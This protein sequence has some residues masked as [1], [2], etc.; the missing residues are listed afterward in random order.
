MPIHFAL[1]RSVLL[2]LGLWASGGF[3]SLNIFGLLWERH[4]ERHGHRHLPHVAEVFAPVA[5][6]QRVSYH[7]SPLS[8]P[9]TPLGA[10]TAA[11][12]GSAGI[13]HSRLRSAA[14]IRMDLAAE[15]GLVSVVIPTH[16]RAHILGRA[17]ES[18]LAQTYRNLQV[19]IADDGSSDDTRS[20][21]ESYGPRITYVR[22]GNA[23]VSAARNFGMRHSRG[24]FIAFLDSDDR[25]QPWKIEAQVNAL[26]RNPD[27]GLVWTDMAAVD[28]AGRLVSD[29]YLRVMY[30][31][32]ERVNFDKSLPQV[33][34]LGDLIEAFG[35][36]PPRGEVRKGDLYSDIL[37]G[38]LIHTSTVLFRRAWCER[39]GGFDE[40]YARAGEDYEFYIRLCSCGP[41]VFINAPST[42]YR[43]GAG[44]Q[45]TAPSMLLEIA[46]NNLRAIQTWYPRSEL[47]IRLSRRVIR[48]RFA[49]S[50]AWLGEAELDAGHRWNAAR[51]L[52]KSVAVMPAL[53]KRVLLV[54]SCVFP[55]GIRNRLLA[56]SR[57]VRATGAKIDG[58]LV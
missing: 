1:S 16:N 11:G 3:F 26:G 23:G 12:V 18:V 44:D 47:Q 46:R 53:D 55:A 37:L 56:A 7:A 15:P 41:V 4:K 45:L 54:A 42:F 58:R 52:S 27:A 36:S 51:Q 49:E 48:R 31:A 50:Y 57:A 17:I 28:E 5:A 8:T 32:Y 13:S 14:P 30:S 33:A 34:N 10:R 43:V 25:W 29:S 20:L 24:E 38:N 2:V 22:Q 6:D 19:V 21:A 9:A 35:A 39:S 40:S